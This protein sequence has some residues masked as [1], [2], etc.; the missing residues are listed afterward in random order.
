M[1]RC[2]FTEAGYN[3]ILRVLV[4]DGY[5]YFQVYHMDCACSTDVLCVLVWD[6]NIS[7]CSCMRATADYQ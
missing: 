5:L 2:Y 7:Q 4:I 3:H 1:V 6:T